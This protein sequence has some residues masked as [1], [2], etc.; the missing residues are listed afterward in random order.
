V[1]IAVGQHVV[2]DLF[3]GESDLAL[4]MV[5]IC[6]ASDCGIQDW[7]ASTKERSHCLR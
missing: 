4:K 3:K 2:V 6:S 5:D 1:R 7:F